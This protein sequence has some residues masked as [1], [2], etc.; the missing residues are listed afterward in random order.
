MNRMNHREDSC[1][2]IRGHLDSYVSKE[3][4]TETSHDVLRHLEKCPACSSELEARTRLRTQLK[5]AVERQSVPP[6]LQV[7]VRE[8]IRAQ[9][10]RSWFDA[11][12]L[13]WAAVAAGVVVSAGLWV[14]YSRER[15]PSLTDRPAQN[16]YIQKVSATL[17]AALR[18]GLMDH[19]HCSIFRK[20]PKGPPPVER[21][22]HELGPSYAGLLPVVKA[23]VPADYRVIMAHE[24]GYAGRKYIHLTMQNGGDLISLVV[25]KKLPGESLATMTETTHSSGV[26]VYESAAGRYEVA[27]FEAGDYLAFV[28]SDLRRKTNLELAV[29][30]APGIREFLSK[31]GA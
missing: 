30:L 9:Q 16:A 27:G 22:E 14:N 10:S 21:M 2:K 5:A 1:E 8:R 17:A 18:A 7:R 11:I 6:E 19:I 12:S 13:R 15:L 31:T 29:N 28:V 26:P 24:C 4:L 23:A 20:Y 25:A 3:L